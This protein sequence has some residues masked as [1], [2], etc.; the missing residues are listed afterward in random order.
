MSFNEFA[1]G[2]LSLADQSGLP[3]GGELNDFV[4]GL[5]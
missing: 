1:R 5:R 4:Q 2:K 3:R